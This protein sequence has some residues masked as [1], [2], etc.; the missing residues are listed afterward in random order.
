VEIRLHGR[1]AENTATLAALAHILTSTTISRRYPDRPPSIHER[2]YLTAT[3]KG[4]EI[5]A[6]G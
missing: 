4:G 6:A 3:T 1:R 5:D 2:I